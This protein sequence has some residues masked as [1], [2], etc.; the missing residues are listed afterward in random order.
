M[1]C[2]WPEGSDLPWGPVRDSLGWFSCASC[3]SRR[4]ICCSL[5]EGGPGV[6]VDTELSSLSLREAA[7][8]VLCPTLNHSVLR[9]KEVRQR[10]RSRE[11]GDLRHTLGQGT[12][13]LCETGVEPL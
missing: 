8:A 5:G 10:G 3:Q 9:G 7:P 12:N 11:L 13:V 4:K 2:L 6:S 1:R